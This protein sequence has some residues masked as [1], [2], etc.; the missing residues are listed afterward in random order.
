MFRFGRMSRL[1]NIYYNLKRLT[2][3]PTQ[4]GFQGGGFTN[5]SEFLNVGSRIDFA[6]EVGDLSNI[7]LCQA[8]IGWVARNL[9]DARLHTVEIGSDNKETEIVDDE[10]AK[11]F[12]RPNEY[13]SGQAL[14]AGIAFDWIVYNEAYLVKTRGGFNTPMELW[15]EPRET[16]RPRWTGGEFISYYELWRDGIW[17]RIES[18][19]V[20]PI[21]NGVNHFTR[22]ALISPAMS[23]ITEFYTEKRAS[24]FINLLLR[25]GLVPP[26]V[27]TLGDK[28]RPF[29]DE[30]KFKQVKSDIKRKIS[31]DGG[32]EPF[33]TNDAVTATRLGYDYSSVGLKEVRQIPISRFCMAMG[34]S[35]I[36]LNAD[37]GDATHANYNNVQGYLKQDY[38]GYIMPLQNLIASALNTH[39]LPDFGFDKSAKVK[40]D[41]S[42]TALMQPDKIAETK[43][44]TLK[45][46]SGGIDKNEYRE[47]LGYAM[48]PEFE[49]VTYFDISGKKQAMANPQDANQETQQIAEQA[50]KSVVKALGFSTAELDE[51][52]QFWRTHTAL[53]DT[54]KS[55]IDAKPYV[56][57][58]P[59]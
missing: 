34:I 39:L 46:V 5:L 44:A 7:T 25:S 55:L 51:S 14:V 21:R 2:E 37:A 56:N 11:L 24:Y 19:D 36:S 27:I 54:A 38:R 52:A 15:W 49:G 43:D 32:G 6:A 26:V 59:S 58:K 42:T 50:A 33:V 45:W 40:W 57:G 48:K 18:D 3:Y 9:Y 13:Y 23:L 53:D 35:P 29:T 4:R 12:Y 20:I 41:Y 1:K 22:R 30:E 8:A 17:K 47:S 28:D 10:L 31:G 16:I